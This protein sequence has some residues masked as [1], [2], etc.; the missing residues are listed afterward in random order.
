MYKYLVVLLDVLS[1]QFTIH[2]YRCYQI[3]IY[4]SCC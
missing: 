3:H 2:I 1:K 4:R